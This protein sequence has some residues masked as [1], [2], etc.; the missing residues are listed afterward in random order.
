M[1]EEDVLHIL[2]HYRH[3]LVNHLQIVQGYLSMDKPDK[4]RSKIESFMDL[5]EG[6][7]KLV[8]LEAPKFALY[9]IQFDTIYQNFRLSYTIHTIRTDLYQLDDILKEQCRYVMGQIT[10]AADKMEL[11]MVHLQLNDMKDQSGV[12]VKLSI[13]GDFIS[14]FKIKSEEN[15]DLPAN[16]RQTDDG[17][18]CSIQIPCN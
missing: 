7:R 10:E 15:M 3:D 2:R 8:N 12:E 5:M 1:R 14:E 9:L 13:Q 18:V 11:Y 16:V 4:A 17:I 6:E